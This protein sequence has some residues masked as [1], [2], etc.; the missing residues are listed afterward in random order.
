MESDMSDRPDADWVYD[1]EQHPEIA[2]KVGVFTARFAALEQILWKLYGIVLGS[3]DER[4]AMVLLGGLQS[5]TVKL[6][7]IERYATYRF[8]K[9]KAEKYKALFKLAKEINRFR[10][11][12]AHGLYMT[13]DSKSVVLI[14]VYL[15]DPK[16]KTA[17]SFVLD[18]NLLD[19][20]V[21]KINR[22]IS[23]AFK[24][25]AEHDPGIVKRR[26]ANI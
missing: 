19:A 17:E 1:L 25:F 2:A 14:D 16:R 12:L 6:D 5:F 23:M 22:A 24:L 4:G 13:D 3:P 7:A 26:T 8:D 18:A 11:E 20:E 21:E 15:T 9:D 10:N